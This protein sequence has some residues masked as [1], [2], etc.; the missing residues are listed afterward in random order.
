MFSGLEY[1]TQSEIDSTGGLV[2]R[3]FDEHVAKMQLTEATIMKQHRLWNEEVLLANRDK[4]NNSTD[5][6]DKSKNKRKG[7]K[8]KDDEE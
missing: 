8:G 6:K 5:N 7:G 4:A 1:Y 3:N 2:T